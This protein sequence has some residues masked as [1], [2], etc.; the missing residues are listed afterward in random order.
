MLFFL[1]IHFFFSLDF[2]RFIVSPSSTAVHIVCTQTHAQ[3][4]EI[5]VGANEFFSCGLPRH[6]RR[7]VCDEFM[8]TSISPGLFL[9]SEIIIVGLR[10]YLRLEIVRWCVSWVYEYVGLGMRQ[11]I[12]AC[13][14]TVMTT[15]TQK[16]NDAKITFRFVV[17]WLSMQS[18]QS[19]FYVFTWTTKTDKIYHTTGVCAAAAMVVDGGDDGCCFNKRNVKSD[20]ENRFTSIQGHCH[21]L[22]TSFEISMPCSMNRTCD[23]LPMGKCLTNF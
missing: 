10:W 7:N 19:T 9:L 6:A 23:A 21:L 4:R 16:N 5:N 11:H 3:R 1:F 12:I 13:V 2:L 14:L 22:K 15:T 8:A 20:Q 18:S 17:C